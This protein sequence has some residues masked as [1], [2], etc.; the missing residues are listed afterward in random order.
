M[1]L[2]IT[3][4]HQPATDLGFLLH[5]H[6]DKLQ[7]V[8]LST[9]KAHIFYQEANHDICTACLMLD[10]NPVE[11]VRSKKG[12]S[13]TLQEHYVNDRPYT[14]N[15]F[16][17]SAITKAFGSALNGKCNTRPELVD[18][19]MPFTVKLASLKVDG[20]PELLDRLF[21]P[22]GYA[23]QFEQ[24]PLDDRFTDWGLSKYVNL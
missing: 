19:P 16:L 21:G 13:P 9:G 14:S 4:T 3:T 18:M 20:G 15:S 8:E 1:I 10:I 24:L 22:L 12:P 2:E 7:T 5:K 6:P 17:S 23:T 11:L